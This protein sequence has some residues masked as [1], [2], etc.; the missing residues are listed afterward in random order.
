RASDKRCGKIPL[1]QSTYKSMLSHGSPFVLGI[2]CDVKKVWPGAKRAGTERIMGVE[3]GIWVAQVPDRSPTTVRVWVPSGKTSANPVR[4][5]TITK[6]GRRASPSSI[7]TSEQVRR[8]LE[9]VKAIPG[10]NVEESMFTVP[11][12]YKVAVAENYVPGG[13]PARSKK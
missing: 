1:T 12:D 8:T 9:L 11:K 10:Q 2:P 7:G 6:I 4:L 13:A 5:E 3:C